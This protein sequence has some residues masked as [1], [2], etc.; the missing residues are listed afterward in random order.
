[1]SA[2]VT[3]RIDENPRGP[4]ERAGE[5]FL[6]P[7]PHRL[8]A[9]RTFSKDS[10]STASRVGYVIGP[11]NSIDYMDRVRAPFAV[12]MAHENGRFLGEVLP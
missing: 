2:L 11:R 9:L 4:S 5:R 7:L 10:G 3:L 6:I 1:M 8:L 12:D